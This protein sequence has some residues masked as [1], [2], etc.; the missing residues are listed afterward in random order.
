[1]LT[2]SCPMKLVFDVLGMVLVVSTDRIETIL[3]S[4][5]MVSEN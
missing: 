3:V 4:V 5:P 1:M 2:V